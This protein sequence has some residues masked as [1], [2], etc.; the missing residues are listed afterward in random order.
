M[1]LTNEHVYVGIFVATLI[2]CT[3]RAM[4]KEAPPLGPS[5]EELLE[6][7]MCLL[8]KSMELSFDTMV[9][10]SLVQSSDYIQKT[11]ERNVANLL[12]P[13]M[14]E[15]KNYENRIEQMVH[16]E[17]LDRVEMKEIINSVTQINR[18]FT[19]KASKFVVS[20][21]G[22]IHSIGRWGED[23]LDNILI[24]SGY[25]EGHD[26]YKHRNFTTIDGRSITPDFVIK[27]PQERILVID[28]KT[29]LDHMISYVEASDETIKKQHA[30]QLVENIKKHVTD[31]SK[32]KYHEIKGE[33][34]SMDYT[35]MFI[36]SDPALFLSLSYDNDLIRDALKKNILIVGP[37]SMMGT[38]RSIEA[39]SRQHK[40]VANLK[41]IALVGKNLTEKMSFFF[42]RLS[43]AQDYLAKSTKMLNVAIN[44][45]SHGEHSLI[46]EVEKLKELGISSEK[47]IVIP[48][49]EEKE[50]K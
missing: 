35:I 18:S 9:N 37:T 41:E 8:K 21:R 22:N 36:S 40:Q 47:T 19:E 49:V 43:D 14:E 44:H 1:T 2:I 27:I 24:A 11:A 50:S 4:K 46:N 29:S 31:L 32:K 20:V 16:E 42:E 15:I 5:I 30:E 28:A 12:R 48:T 33:L 26:Y 3:I 45:L 13:M 34:T 6:N 39:L 38:L 17:N 25:A 7:K 10:R 23:S